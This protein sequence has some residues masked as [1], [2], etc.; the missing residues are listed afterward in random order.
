VNRV[1]FDKEYNI[2]YMERENMLFLKLDFLLFLFVL[3]K[4]GQ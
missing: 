3:I 2:Q 4:F 1:I